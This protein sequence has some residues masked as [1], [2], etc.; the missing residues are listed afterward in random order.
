MPNPYLTRLREQH[1]ALH[2]SIEG[3]QTRAAEAN[4]DLS[5]DEFRSVTDQAAQLKKL[6]AQIEDLAGV[7]Q[8]R[9]KV[10]ELA[11]DLDKGAEQG[12]EQ[13]LGGGEQSRSRVTT[14]DRDP[15]HYRSVTDGGQHSFFGDHYRAVKHGD[16]EAK[17]RLDEHMRAV[18]QSSGG[19]GIIPPKWLTDEYQGLARQNRVVADLVRHI[20][21]GQ[22]PRP[23]V[24][25][26]QTGGTDANITTQTT[27]GA[28]NAGWGTDRY[29]SDVDTLTPVFKAAWQDVSRQ[30]LDASTPAVDSLIFG[31]LRAAWDTVVEA[32]TCAA[33]LG[34]TGTAAGTTFATEAAFA[35]NAAA[36][37]AVIDAQT[38]VAGDQRGPADLAVMN[39]RRF[40]AFR[41]LK[42]STNRPL[43]PVSRYSPQNATGALDNRLV[44]DIEGVD[45]VASSG[46]PTAYAETYAVLRR[47]AVLLAESGVQDFTYEQAGGP[48]FV[49]MGL[50]GYVGTLVRNP[51]GISIQTVTA[52]S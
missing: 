29:T 39:F 2:A 5:D 51:G 32:L 25:P 50:W 1:D 21:L 30:L 12:Q 26:K 49:R 11:A 35:T 18:T 38:A 20:D 7:E 8:S 31:D 27:E 33:I 16:G 3:L 46:V 6:T 19:A 44:G 13:N 14:R 23:L 24:L 36:I 10:G 52:A 43:M 28:N 47:N 45:A 4:R 34:A 37:D 42:D 40:G 17:K 22:D 48:A 41:K 15:G 9:A